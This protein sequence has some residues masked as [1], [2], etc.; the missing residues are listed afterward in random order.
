MSPPAWL[1]NAISGVR[2]LLVPTFWVVAWPGTQA[3]AIAGWAPAAIVLLLIGGSDLLD[4]ALARRYGLTSRSGVVLDAAADRLA[5]L[6]VTAWF[7]F[8]DPRIPLWFLALLVG[9]DALIGVGSWLVVRG[10]HAS[11]LRHAPHGK[12]AT[13]VV[14]ALSLSLV[15][16]GLE[17]LVPW[18]LTAATGAILLSTGAYVVL[19]LRVGRRPATRSP[20]GRNRPAA[21]LASP[22]IPTSRV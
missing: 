2:I 22:R 8:V 1:P 14:F 13:A 7:V 11:V 4:G 6:G 9:R 3:D 19:G 21:A 17:A 16:P 20:A 18:A 12:A 5:Q 10:G 15:L